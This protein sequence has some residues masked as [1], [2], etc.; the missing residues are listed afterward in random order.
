[1]GDDSG[2]VENGA[3]VVR[4][5]QPGGSRAVLAS[6]PPPEKV[7]GRCKDSVEVDVTAAFLNLHGHF[8]TAL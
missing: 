4:K 6:Q 1:M 8:F 3:P 2:A 5:E 7:E